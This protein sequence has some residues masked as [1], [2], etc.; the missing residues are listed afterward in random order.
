MQENQ[1]HV[2]TYFVA[3]ALYLQWKMVFHAVQPKDLFLRKNILGHVFPNKIAALVIL[4][5]RYMII[6]EFLEHNG[7]HLKDLVPLDSPPTS[8]LWNV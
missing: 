3:T 7:L 8:A 2:V 6:H 4:L 1:H 5:S